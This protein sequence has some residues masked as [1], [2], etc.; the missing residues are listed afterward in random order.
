MY[1]S[2]SAHSS[3]IFHALAVR[4]RGKEAEEEDVE[5]EERLKRGVRLREVYLN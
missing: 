3:R 2:G 4:D 1:G 5:E